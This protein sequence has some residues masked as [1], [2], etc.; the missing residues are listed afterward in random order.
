[1]NDLSFQELKEKYAVLAEENKSLKARIVE[2][3]SAL[4]LTHLSHL[5]PQP[6]PTP[7]P[8]AP[9]ASMDISA[10]IAD[11]PVN[12]YSPIGDKVALFMSLNW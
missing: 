7:D 3:E 5:A 10:D 4:R 6:D 2:L 11:K 9:G 8:F 12:H 1:M